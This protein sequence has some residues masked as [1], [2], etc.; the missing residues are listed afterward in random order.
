MGN[1]RDIKYKLIKNFLSEDEVNLARNYMLHRH[2]ENY[3]DFDFTQNNNCDTY[4]Y[5][6]PL[7][8]SLLFLKLKK[9]EEETGLELFPTYSFARLYTYNAEL[10]PHKDRPSCEISVTVMYG[11]C[12]EKWPI[13]M[14]D[15][16]VDMKPGD[17]CIYMGCE[18]NHYRKNFKG[19]WHA[20]AFLHYVDKNGP[21]TEYKF[22]KRKICEDY[23][24]K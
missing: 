4:L 22:D 1:I 9:M 12:G 3:E 13:Y 24:K 15:K 16:P 19:D 20:Q 14:D 17:A 11:S 6:D 10:K 21:Y 8:E 18:L 5:N 23:F 7:S 2:K